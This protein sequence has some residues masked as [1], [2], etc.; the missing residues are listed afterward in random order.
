MDGRGNPLAIRLT[1]GNTHDIVEAPA[2]LKQANGR[3]FIADKGYDSNALI[4]AILERGMNAVIP[5]R[6]NRKTP[7]AYDLELYKERHRVEFYFN[8]LK[9]YRRVATRYDKN[10]SQFLGFVLVASIRIWLI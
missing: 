5:P 1:P 3:N 10:A 7:R 9:Q 8:K 6:S 4:V 2:L